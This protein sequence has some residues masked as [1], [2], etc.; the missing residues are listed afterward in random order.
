VPRMSV[1]YTHLICAAQSV[2]PHAEVSADDVNARL[3]SSFSLSR[4]DPQSSSRILEIAE[5][6]VTSARHEY[7][8]KDSLALALALS[9]LKGTPSPKACTLSSFLPYFVERIG[10]RTLLAHGALYRM[11]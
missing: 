10:G 6:T 2:L 3:N 9:F 7:E 5:R 11:G 1:I 8:V 4:P